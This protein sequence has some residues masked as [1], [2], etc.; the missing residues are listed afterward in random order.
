MKGFMAK[1]Y[2]ALKDFDPKGSH[3]YIIDTNMWLYLFSPISSA[4]IKIQESIGRFIQNCKSVGANVITTSFIVA[5]YFHASLRNEFDDWVV[6]QGVSTKLTI[7]K[8]Y[9]PTDEYA[10]WIEFIKSTIKNI[11]QI[12]LPRD[13][14]FEKIDRINIL[15]NSIHAE[16]FD[17]HT[18]ELAND[19][20]WIIVSNDSDL[21]NHP[22]RKS[23]LLIP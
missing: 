13:D 1:N 10:D 2:T 7:K 22:D 11:Y 6:A 17:N 19:N 5:E 14:N 8:H 3:T 18:L 21:L 9:R 20:G 4:E 15:D 16:Y 23:L 12:A